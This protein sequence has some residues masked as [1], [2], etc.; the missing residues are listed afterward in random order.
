MLTFVLIC[1]DMRLVSKSLDCLGNY[2]L[3]ATC[4]VSLQLMGTV[5]RH[6]TN[7]APNV[8]SGFGGSKLGSVFLEN[9]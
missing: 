4:H 7:F 9:I 6:L 1:C 3:C 2:S 8:S 5:D